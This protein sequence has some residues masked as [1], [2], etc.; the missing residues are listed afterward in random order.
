MRLSTFLTVAAFSATTLIAQ[1]LQQ[2]ADNLTVKTPS[3]DAKKLSI[4]RVKGA[5]VSLLAADY[6]Q[7]I[8]EKGRITRPLTDTNVRVSFKLT[9]G[10][11]SA[12]SRDYELTIKGTRKQDA[13]ANPKPQVIPELLSWDGGKGAYKLPKELK[14]YGKQ[15][16]IAEFIRELN[17]TLPEGYKAARTEDMKEADVAF[18]LMKGLDDETYRLDIDKEKGIRVAGGSDTGLYWATRTILQLLVQN[19]AE[20]P[21]GEA[22]DMPRF[23]VRGFML[24]VGRLPIP[25]DYVKEVVRLMAWYKMNDL[26]LHLNDN[27]IFHEH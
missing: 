16:F 20:L 3:A 5:E 1:D 22:L 10:N 6:E 23:K 25:M 15:R 9:K 17:E 12:I 26:Q 2:M 11:Q 19:P 7:I 4:P 27:Y 14:V 24:D 18:G 8:N 13:G 21:C